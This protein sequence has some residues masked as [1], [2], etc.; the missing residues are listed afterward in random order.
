MLK[1][2]YCE[3]YIT[4]VCNLACTGCNRFNNYKFTGYQRW[5]DYADIYAKWSRELTFGSAAIMGGEPMLNPSFL[6]WVQ[7]ISQLWP[8]RLLRI[9]SNGFRLHKHP[10]LYELLRT[11][12]QIQLWV[13]IHNK[14]HKKQIIDTVK[15]FLKQPYRIEFNTD[16][17]YQQYI[18]LIDANDVKVRI[19]Y[20]WWFH[21]GAILKTESG[22]LGLHNS[23]MA[24]AHEICHMKTCHHFS[25]GKLYK[26]G[27]A[28]VLP[29]F[30]QQHN[31]ELT[32]S[33]REILYSYRPLDIT[34]SAEVKKTF[35]DRIDQPIDLCKFCPEEYHGD[36][37][38][39][40][41]KK[42][43]W[44]KNKK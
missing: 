44:S 30:D 12:R 20:N 38:W 35:I 1:L 3:F 21:Q 25:Q 24:K 10:K 14:Q 28:A 26:C 4:N 5:S 33:D 9:I 17:P 40:Q 8:T 34:D 15:N 13:G 42:I 7:G 29:D 22:R 19:E 2:D 16:N 11:N 43:S 23:D 37:I 31:L 18:M 32:N 36:Q 39:S 41:E 27:V 6:D